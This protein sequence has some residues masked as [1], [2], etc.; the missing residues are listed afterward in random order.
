MSNEQWRINIQLNPY[1]KFRRC[2]FSV[3]HDVVITVANQWP[4]GYYS[5]CFFLLWFLP[6]SKNQ[7]IR[8]KLHLTIMVWLVLNFRQEIHQSH[9]RNDLHH[10][11]ALVSQQCL[12]L[13]AH[14]RTSYLALYHDWLRCFGQWMTRT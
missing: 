1:S 13:I 4:S 9:Y 8:E 5:D 6:N 10:L 14:S 2:L 7:A 3:N 12:L 11:A